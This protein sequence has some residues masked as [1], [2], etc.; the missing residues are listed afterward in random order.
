MDKLQGHILIRRTTLTS[1]WL[2]YLS[3][4][5]LNNVGTIIG[6]TLNVLTILFPKLNHKQGF[7]SP[8]G[9]TFH[10]GHATGEAGV[11]SDLCRED[12]LHKFGVYVT[13]MST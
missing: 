3:S 6:Y 5:L 12:A 4:F 1:R 2:K 11:L 7:K 8:W 9:Q 13:G 10:W